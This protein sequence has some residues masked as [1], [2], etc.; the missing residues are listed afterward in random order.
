M[1]LRG[2]FYHSHIKLKSYFLNSLL[3]KEVCG[4]YRAIYKRLSQN[5][6]VLTVD[7][8]SKG[9]ILTV[10]VLVPF[11][12]VIFWSRKHFLWL[13]N[14][15]PRSPML[16]KLKRNRVFILMSPNVI[17]YQTWVFMVICKIYMVIE[18]F[19]DS[20]ERFW[21]KILYRNL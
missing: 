17:V 2:K 6:T 1:Y 19:W 7:L 11:F 4:V 9:H 14:Q 15:S 16:S 20:W 10:M 12:M 13:Q 5:Y 18:I 8:T 21:E 3:W